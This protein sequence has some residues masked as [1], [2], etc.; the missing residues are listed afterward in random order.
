[1]SGLRISTI[2]IMLHLPP[3][4]GL[5]GR[6]SGVAGSA[7][8]T[9]TRP[10][11]GEPLEAVNLGSQ[12]RTPEA[13]PSAWPRKRSFRRS[14]CCRPTYFNASIGETRRRHYNSTPL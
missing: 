4:A 14:V 10:G 11:P 8:L 13:L 12:R 7:P 9:R 3:A 2:R 1:M 6:E 5:L